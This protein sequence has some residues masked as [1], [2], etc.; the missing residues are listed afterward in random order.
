MGGRGRILREVCR[1]GGR[2]PRQGVGKGVATSAGGSAGWS[3]RLP[4]PRQQPSSRARL[5]REVREAARVARIERRDAAAP[6]EPHE[7][8]GER[9]HGHAAPH[10]ELA[11]RARP[12]LSVAAQL[13]EDVVDGGAPGRR[14]SSRECAPAPSTRHLRP[15]DFVMRPIPAQAH[16][17]TELAPVMFRCGPPRSAGSVR[18]APGPSSTGPSRREVSIVRRNASASSSLSQRP[19][20]IE[21]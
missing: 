11:L 18:Q 19:E 2:Q 16:V 13:R 21:K 6:A 9:S 14:L 3:A 12:V 10:R 20:R 7:P 15:L 4:Q 5:S 8:G 17:G 1:Q